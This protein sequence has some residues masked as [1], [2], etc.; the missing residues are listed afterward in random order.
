V[1]TIHSVAHKKRQVLFT[2]WAQNDL[3]EFLL[4]MIDC[5]H[6]EMKRPVKMNISGN[7]ENA[8]DNLAFKCYSM[9]K[10]N[11]EKGDYS[12][13]STLFNGIYVSRLSMTRGG[14]ESQKPE[15]FTILDL[16][17][18]QRR[19]GITLLDCLNEF[20]KKEV[21]T[22][23]INETT[24]IAEPAEKDIV[25]W[26]FP[27][28]LIITLKRFSADGRKNDALVDFPVDSIL[29]LSDYSVG[30]KPKS[31]KYRLFGVANHMGDVGGGH[32]TS[33]ARS[34]DSEEWFLYNDSQVFHVSN[35]QEIVSP[36]AYCLWFRKV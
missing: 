32:Y 19:C 8:T 15:Q 20:V 4:F 5:M 36:S 14:E 30:Y 9:L 16:P 6:D 34:P 23:W 26:S 27:Q 13:L 17:L 35:I 24:K 12:E 3:S 22:D 10:E 28:I 2:G 7:I 1:K 33:Y 21:L 31:N 18:P 29:D 25:F 11:Y